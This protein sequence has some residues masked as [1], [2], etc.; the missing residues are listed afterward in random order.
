VCF[1]EPPRSQIPPPHNRTSSDQYFFSGH[2][3]AILAAILFPVF[4]RARE[5]A[6]QTSCLSNTK[7]L[8]LAI[9]MY[10]DDHSETL[11]PSHMSQN[12]PY[13]TGWP[14]LILPYINNTGI[15]ECPSTGGASPTFRP[16]PS[17]TARYPMSYICNYYV[18]SGN[19]GYHLARIDS[20]SEQA[21]LGERYNEYEGWGCSDRDADIRLDPTIHNGGANLNFADGHAK[22]LPEGEFWGNFETYWGS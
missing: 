17:G 20:P 1:I 14:Q 12:V 4:A 22:W 5:K 6:R 16:G 13:T 10:A 19:V 7:Q 9:L 2:I 15:F 8:A 21:L 18:M 11:P 3:I